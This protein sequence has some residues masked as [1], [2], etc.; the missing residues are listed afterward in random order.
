MCDSEDHYTVEDS[1]LSWEY[2]SGSG[3]LRVQT[4]NN[5]DSATREITIRTRDEMEIQVDG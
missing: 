3:W 1:P 5:E 2:P 4:V